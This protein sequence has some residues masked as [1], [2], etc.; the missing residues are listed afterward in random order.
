MLRKR[1][2]P[3]RDIF[4]I[5]PWRLETIHFARELGDQFL[6]PSETAFA[7]ANGYLG[8]RGSHEEDRPVSEPGTFLNGFYENRPIVDGESAYGFPNVG[9]TI[10]NCPDG[11]IIKLYVDDEPFDLERSEILSVVR[12][13]A[14]EVTQA[15][16]VRTSSS[17]IDST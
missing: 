9:Q 16:L 14:G 1:L 13:D 5:R 15:H 11:K 17:M 6:G 7:Q 10:L 3:P 4:P 2:V 12:H 8:L